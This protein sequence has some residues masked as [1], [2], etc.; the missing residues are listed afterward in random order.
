MPCELADGRGVI[1]GM[2]LGQDVP[3]YKI[4]EDP[5]ARPPPHWRH[6]RSVTRVVPE[7]ERTGGPAAALS[8]K[9]ARVRQREEHLVMR[10]DKA[11]AAAATRKSDGPQLVRVKHTG[12]Q[13]PS[14]YDGWVQPRDSGE[15]HAFEHSKV[16]F[17]PRRGARFDRAA[18][19][20]FAAMRRAGMVAGGEPPPTIADERPTAQLAAASNHTAAYH[21]AAAAA[22]S[23]ADA[24]LLNSLL[25][26][27]G[28]TS[29]TSMRISTMMV[30]T[31]TT[32]AYA[33]TMLGSTFTWTI[34]HL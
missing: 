25:H 10:L 15:W 16:H 9:I 4:G 19:D 28:L 29:A 7:P 21:T 5:V 26:S 24:A 31:F 12:G 17:E 2:R 33:F 8:A 22:R 1:T 23:A 27:A 20:R 18:H 32:I 11:R 14:L 13:H 3:F 34:R 30:S 6:E